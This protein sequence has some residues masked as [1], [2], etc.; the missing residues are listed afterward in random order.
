MI[1]LKSEYFY[2]LPSCYRGIMK[3]GDRIIISKSL[4]SSKLNVRM[5]P[6]INN[7]RGRNSIPIYGF[8]IKQLKN[9]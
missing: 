4:G 7:N 8:R 2:Y 5:T 1:T 9:I 3:R 6:Y